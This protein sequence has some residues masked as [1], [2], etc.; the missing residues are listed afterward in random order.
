MNFLLTS[1]DIFVLGCIVQPHTVAKLPPKLRHSVEYGKGGRKR[2]R[3]ESTSG[4]YK[5]CTQTLSSTIGL[6]RDS[7]ALNR[8]RFRTAPDLFTRIRLRPNDC[9]VYRQTPPVD[10]TAV[11]VPDY[12]SFLRP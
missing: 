8:T 4:V 9:A 2:K 11:P 6:V 1:S 10:G 3:T 5:R 12:I 7:Y